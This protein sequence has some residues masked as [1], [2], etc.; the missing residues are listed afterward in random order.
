MYLAIAAM[1]TGMSIAIC[2]RA[3]VFD[4]PMLGAWIC[5]EGQVNYTAQNGC[6][7]QE[8]NRVAWWLSCV[9]ERKDCI[10]SDTAFLGLTDGRYGYPHSIRGPGYCYTG[11]PYTCSPDGRLP[12]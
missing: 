2:A 1:I 4:P 3:D 9:P 7:P 11:Q 8:F 12:Q 10:Y 5:P 6:K